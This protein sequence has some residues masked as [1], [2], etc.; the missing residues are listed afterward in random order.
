VREKGNVVYN[1]FGKLE[2]KET[3]KVSPDYPYGHNGTVSIN[4]RLKLK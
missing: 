1:I 2:V 3:K 4:K